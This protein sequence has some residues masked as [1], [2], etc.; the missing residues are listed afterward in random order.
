MAY[1]D[2]PFGVSEYWDG[3]RGAPDGEG[4]TVYVTGVSL[5]LQRGAP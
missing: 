1:F 5:R 2:E 3:I 4:A